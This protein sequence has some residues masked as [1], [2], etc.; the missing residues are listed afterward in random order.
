VVQIEENQKS[1]YMS[2][3]GHVYVELP[4]LPPWFRQLTPGQIQDIAKLITA[5]HALPERA[6]D[7]GSIYDFDE[8]LALQEVER[9]VILRAIH[10]CKG[11]VPKAAAALGVGKTTIYRKLREW[12]ESKVISQASAGKGQPH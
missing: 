3:L 12:S 7:H 6:G 4:D 8:I 1:I 9:D 5:W 10:V 2:A 11:N